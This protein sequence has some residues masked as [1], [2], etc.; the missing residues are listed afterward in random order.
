MIS[1]A[2]ITSQL[3]Y[4][5][6]RS[7]YLNHLEATT[8]QEAGEVLTEEQNEALVA[9]EKFRAENI[10]N[11]EEVEEKIRKMRGSY[12]DVASVVRPESFRSQTKY[13]PFLLGDN[14][15]LMLLGMA[16][17]QWGFF[18]GNWKRRHYRLTMILG[19]GVG[20]P[21]V[22]FAQ[23]HQV[24]YTPTLETGIEYMKV[25]PFPWDTS[26]Y[27]VQ[28]IFLSMGHAAMLMLVIHSGSLKRLMNS[29][30]AVG[31]MAFSNYILQS[32]LCTLF[33]FGYGLGYYERLELHQLYYVVLGVWIISMILS[34]IWLKYYRFGPLEWLWRSL[35]YWK[36]MPFS[37]QQTFEP[38]VSLN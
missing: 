22:I 25:H 33:F 6:I 11:P 7:K 8:A 12:A 3:Y 31:Q 37:R 27:H 1:I 38:R 26:V 13:L 4:A 23:W 36:I 28:R 17:L 2:I 24:T 19:F 5:D 14:V 35:T 29:L 9:W 16:L 18:S 10:P 32:I 21:L 34:P 15:S 30:R 20:L